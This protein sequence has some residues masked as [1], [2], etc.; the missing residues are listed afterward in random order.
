MRMLKHVAVA[1]MVLAALGCGDSRTKMNRT[2]ASVRGWILDIEHPTEGSKRNP[3]PEIEAQRRIEMFQ[4]TNMVVENVGHAS[5]GIG[6]NG[7]F[8][9]LDVPPG[10]SQILFQ[11]AMGD[12]TLELSGIPKN[13]DVLL[14]N[15]VIR[16][17]KADV[18]QPSLIV[19][20]VPSRAVTKAREI[21][22]AAKVNGV[23]VRVFETPLDDMKDRRDYPE[24]QL[25]FRPI[26]IVK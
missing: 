9:I 3:V 14:P 24:P 26:A 19:V 5:G 6:D 17:P 2:P 12:A 22:G 21:P 11:T 10:S 23:D 8:V 7:A 25:G 18:L 15:L 16:P 20:R 13:A 4:Q 1:L